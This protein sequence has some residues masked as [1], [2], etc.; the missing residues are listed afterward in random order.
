MRAVDYSRVVNTKAL[1]SVVSFLQA[2]KNRYAD[3]EL[4][5]LF[6]RSMVSVTW[7]LDVL[8]LTHLE[9]CVEANY[10]WHQTL[11][12]FSQNKLE[13]NY[14]ALDGLPSWLRD[15]SI[16][17]AEVLTIDQLEKYRQMEVVLVKANDIE[18]QCRLI[19]N[20]HIVSLDCGLYTYLQE[21]C[22]FIL[23]GYRIKQ[24]CSENSWWV[25]TEP[26]K[27]GATLF[28]AIADILQ[29]GSS[30][31]Q[32]PPS[33]MNTDRSD[34]L[35]AREIV[36]AQLA[37]IFG[38]EIGHIMCHSAKDIPQG[39]EIEFEADDFSMDILK[40]LEIQVSVINKSNA[41]IKLAYE[42][43]EVQ[44]KN[45]NDRKIEAVEILFAFYGMYNYAC[46]KRG[47]KIPKND[48]HPEIYERRANI[49][50]R[51]SKLAQKPLAIYADD[52]ITKIK[53]EIDFRVDNNYGR[54]INE[55]I[56]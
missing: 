46:Q 40:R 14:F 42:N 8:F 27:S 19:G 55:S 21:W 30:V 48:T 26:I 35:I 23:Q 52:L 10:Q 43:N 2:N 34:F 53:R 49:S 45:P 7:K 51:Y 18:A 38:H 13:G 17:Y 4:L 3:E 47:Y 31:Y 12:V 41:G 9:Q 28:L 5:F 1:T 50:K 39:K 36:D 15:I 29:G 56:L 44:S 16:R 11:S 33:A 24:Y 32:M 25:L 6:L 54:K 20:T 37:F 22:L